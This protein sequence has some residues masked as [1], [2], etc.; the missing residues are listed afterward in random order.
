MFS[1]NQTSSLNT[2]LNANPIDMSV[3]TTTLIGPLVRN[4]S[5]S[6]LVNFPNNFDCWVMG[7]KATS[8]S[9]SS[10]GWLGLNQALTS[11]NFWLGGSGIR[12]APLLLNNSPSSN[13][14]AM[15]TSPSGKVH[16]KLVGAAP[17]RTLVVEYQNMTISSAVASSTTN[18]AT[19]Q[20]RVYEATGIIEFVYGNINVSGATAINGNIGFSNTLA[21]FQSI[22]PTNQTS[23]SLTNTNISLST[24]VFSPLIGGGTA[25]TCRAYVFTPSFVSPSA[26]S[27]AP[28]NS[29]SITLNWTNHAVTANPAINNEIYYSI[30]GNDWILAATLAPTISTYQL[31]GLLP[32]T[33]YLFKVIAIRESRS[34]ALAGNA[35]TLIAPL[36]KSTSS[37]G[38]W[39]NP[40]TWLGGV[41]PNV[42]DSV[43][44]ANGASVTIDTFAQ[45]YKLQVGEGVSGSLVYE[46]T[47][48]RLLSVTE[49]LMV[50]SGA[51]FTA[52]SGT[53]NFHMLNLGSAATAL[54][55]GNLINNGIF[56]M[57]TTA[58]VGVTFFGAQNASISGS[59]TVTDFS[60]V[61]LNK[62]NASANRPVLNIN[63]P[64]T[65]QGANTIG[66]IASH[67]AGTLKINGNFTQSNPIYTVNNY[68]IPLNA[69][70]V[71]NNPNFTITSTNGNPICNGLL[72]ITQGIFNVSQTAAQELGFGIGSLFIVEG[73][74]VNA[75]ARIRLDNSMTFN[76]SNGVINVAVVGNNQPSPSFGNISP[77]SLIN[78]S[79]GALNLV[80][81]SSVTSG[82]DYN[83]VFDPPRVVVTGGILNVGTSA[84]T[85]NFNFRISGLIPS[86]II[87]TNITKKTAT[88]SNTIGVARKLVVPQ[89][90][91]LILLANTL[92]FWGDSII[93]NGFIDGRHPNSRIVFTGSLIRQ[94]YAG[95]GIDSI[96]T[97]T[98][99]SVAGVLFNKPIITYGVVLSG[100]SQFMNSS[101][102]VLGNGLNQAVSVQFG[103]NG[104]N[105]LT[106][107][108]GFDVAPT[109]NMGAG[110][111]TL[112]YLREL[113]PRITGNEIPT[114]RTITNLNIQSFNNNVI[115]SGGN[116]YITGNL[117][118][119]AKI[120]SSDTAMLHLL[121]TQANAVGAGNGLSYIVGGLVRRLPA[122]LSGSS[123]YFFPLGSSRLCQAGLVNIKTNA[124]GT[125]DIKI[126]YVDSLPGGTPDGSTFNQFNPGYFSIEIVS[127]SANIDSTVITFSQPVL[128]RPA[129][130]LVYSNTLNGTYS[131]ISSNIIGPYTSNMRIG[132]SS[133][134]GFYSVG[135][136][137]IPISGNFLAGASKTAPHYT[138]ITQFINDIYQKELQ[139]NV[140]LLLDTDY[141]SSNETFPITLNRFYSNNPNWTITIKPNVGVNTVISGTSSSSIINILGAQKYIIDGSNNNST[142]RN[143]TV[144]NQS[145]ATNTAAIWISSYG[146]STG[147]SNNIIRNLKISCGADQTAST[148]NTFGVISCDYAAISI[149]SRGNKNDSNQIIN[150]EI[151]KVRYGIFSIGGIN[152]T[153]NYGN[154]IENNIIGPSSFGTNQ[155]GKAGIVLNA[156]QNTI[157]DNNEIRF[158]GG[159]F[160]QLAAGTDRVGISLASDAIWTPTSVLVKQARVTRN[161]IHD[162]VDEKIFSAIGIIVA[163]MD[164]TNNT[165]NVIANNDIYSISSNGTTANSR[166]TAGIAL[167]S[168]KQDSLLFNTVNLNGFINFSTISGSTSSFGLSIASSSVTNAI[169]R[170]NLVTMDV[171][172]NFVSRFNAAINIP[173][174]YVWGTGMCNNNLLFAPSNNPQ[175]R[176]GCVGGSNGTFYQTLSNWQTA[177][178]QDI[179]SIS[180]NPLL[181]SAFVS[182]P[183]LNS[184]AV[185]AGFAIAGHNIDLLDSARSNPPTI[186]AYE[187]SADRRPPSISFSNLTNDTS[188]TARNATS[189]AI[190][191]DS[192]GINNIPGLK[193]R[194][195][196]KKI[197]DANAFGAN[198]NSANGWKWVEA[199][200]STSPY[201]FNINY[202]LLFTTASLNDTIQYF[203]VAQ[204]NSP[205]ANISSFPAVGFQATSLSNIISAP[206]TLLTY[207]IVLPALAGNYFIGAGQPFL[208][209][210]SATLSAHESGV[211]A[212]VTFILTD[213]LY[214]TSTGE[215][216]PIEVRTI[217]GAS[218]INQVTLRPNNGIR[219]IIRDSINNPL[220]NLNGVNHF[221]I[222]G[223]Q[224]SSGLAK[225]LTVSNTHVGAN[226]GAVRFINDASNNKLESAIFLG[227]NAPTNGNA[228]VV[229][230][231]TG[232]VT[233]N[234]KNNVN[235]CE[236]GNASTTNRPST[237]IYSAGSTDLL[238]KFNDSNNVTNC[239]LYN[240]SN[241]T[242]EFNAFKIVNGNNT[243]TISENHVY[244]TTSIITS[245]L[246]FVFNLENGGN[247]NAL[248]NIR[249]VRN[250][251]GGSAPF[252]GGAPWTLSTSAGRLSSSFNLGNL[253]TSLFKR[254][255]ICNF[256]YNSTSSSTTSWQ[257]ANFIGG[258]LNI[259]SN[260]IGSTT[261]RDS[262]IISGGSNSRA[263]IISLNTEEPGEYSISG[264]DF[265]AIVVRSSSPGGASS[266]SLINTG[267][268]GSLSVKYNIGGNLF[269]NTLDS[270]ILNNTSGSF[271]YGI[272]CSTASVINIRNNI[273]RNFVYTNTIGTPFVAAITTSG[274][275]IDTI[276]DNHIFDMRSNVGN[277]IGIE[278]SKPS[279]AINNY[280]FRNR[281]F[282]LTSRTV[283]GILIT[284][285]SSSSLENNLIYGLA[286]TGSFGSLSGI[287]VNDWTGTGTRTRIIN[288]MIS[289]GHRTNGSNINSN[290]PIVGIGVFNGTVSAFNNSVYI[291]GHSVVPGFENTF[292]FSRN[293]SIGVDSILNNIFM[294]V[295]SNLTASG[296]KNYAL[297]MGSKYSLV[298][299]YNL[300][301]VD[302]SNFGNILARYEINTD[303]STLTSFKSAILTDHYSIS[304]NPN[305]IAPNASSTFSGLHIN[306]STPTP[307]ESAGTTVV[308]VITDFDNQN[309]AGLTPE[310]I[311]ADAGNFAVL[312]LSSPRISYNNFI[313][314]TVSNQ[315]I[316][317]GQVIVTDISGIHAGIFKPR[318]YY[319]KK[320]N[321]NIFSGN[322]SS[323]NGWKFVE[324]SNNTSPFNFIIDY[325]ILTGGG[326]VVGDTIQYFVIAQDSLGYLAAA[327]FAGLSA[328]SVI[329]IITAPTSPNF[330]AIIGSPLRGT[331]LVGPTQSAP[332]FTSLT[333]AV[334]E[335][336]LRGAGA[337]VIFELTSTLYTSP[338]E[339]FPIV[340]KEIP[341]SSALNS[342]TIKP[343]IGVNSHI[344]TSSSSPAIILD[345]ADYITIDGSNNG[346]TSRNLRF[347]TSSSV[348]PAMIWGR[349][350]SSN[351]PTTFNTIKNA[352]IIGTDAGIGIG[353]GSTHIGIPSFGIGN[354]NNTITN[355][356]LRNVS[357]G[358]YLSG[359]S[360]AVKD[361]NNIISFNILNNSFP[362]NVGQ[363]GI[364]TAFQNNLLVENN[365]I[366]N[367]NNDNSPIIGIAL[368]Y[369]MGGP[370][371]EVT[372]AIIRNNIIGPIANSTITGS[373]IAYGIL[374][375]TANSGI[376]S[377]HNNLISDNR[378]SFSL[379]NGLTGIY[380]GG[381]E[382]STT[383]VLHNT[384][385]LSGTLS[386]TTTNHYAVWIDTENPLV[387]MRNNIVTNTLITSGTGK[388]FAIGLASTT[389]SNMQADY[390]NYFV[391]GSLGKL[392]IS[393]GIGVGSTEYATLNAF[394]A[395]IGKD[396]NSVS[397]AVTFVSTTDAHLA[398]ASIGDTSL[399]CLLIPGITRDIDNELRNTTF[400][401]MGADEIVSNPLPVKLI[402]FNAQAIS[403]D[404]R[405]TWTTAAEVNNKGFELER[406]FD[407]KTFEFAQF[408]DG[409]G[410]SNKISSYQ[411][412]DAGI[413]TKTPVIYY[414]LKQ[415][416]FNSRFEYSKTVMVS[417]PKTSSNE[418]VVYPNPTSGIISL[419]INT[420]VEEH[421]EVT[422][423]DM[424]GK[425]VYNQQL[426]AQ[427]GNNQITLQK[428]EELISG[429]YFVRV[430]G[431]QQTQVIKLVKTN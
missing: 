305:F 406:S 361:Q 27:F 228:G 367:F 21:S 253:G 18:D 172:S 407:G 14:P 318:I 163:G 214:N 392:A 264:N 68:V 17:N 12:V 345:G 276:S 35:S 142:S 51:S 368:G 169:I 265:G 86:L 197:Q 326:V 366:G 398:G 53:N 132:A 357:T 24:G 282:G 203:V 217:P 431:Q 257:V 126:K 105:G 273:F 352:T 375:T 285:L 426:L 40:T 200:N 52:G 230:F 267:S 252:C 159:L 261:G 396:S 65:V 356:D 188:L 41:V 351:N 394:R 26:L 402:S 125:V 151:T 350:T 62:G 401:Y 205:W 380:L 19:F 224:T 66:L 339:S 219:A 146:G 216:F 271:L 242:N 374:L 293:V 412:I 90:T 195:Y 119:S 312:D 202:N 49:S 399:R 174:S 250:Y 211:V 183:Y 180:Q 344:R 154:R 369:N 137:I 244:Q 299:D 157:I 88:L 247:R 170:N 279:T 46:T 118:L 427:Q 290:I 74:V 333:Q 373:S 354:N 246:H 236:I 87:D 414:R 249:I 191:T 184:P 143:L 220:F 139:G 410:N 80:Q 121:N 245:A 347:S 91:S 129:N 71:L 322:T 29:T 317:N 255:K 96:S 160:S 379:T 320:T 178:G 122:S 38:S 306:P 311:G 292:A 111:Y 102:I 419:L 79:G 59:G 85:N 335:I 128:R 389:F 75:A 256:F 78:W 201:G 232:L 388:N 36:V 6:G 156:E 2:D 231:G 238:T 381:G 8:F 405:V 166:Q 243:W 386:N 124:G 258:K 61:T 117:N 226:A 204:D 1:T 269:G 123:T 376:N 309:R 186:G 72:Q 218:A 165:G 115:L 155:I 377:I 300:Y 63:I 198:N 325:T 32:A 97:I 281:I 237:L 391:S 98:N 263:N 235:N 428:S 408:I 208:T 328:T 385:T 101:N 42:G 364:V 212:P 411:Y 130:R 395:A 171:S 383:R 109:F 81:R 15:G 58:G 33:N 135:D 162:I 182:I 387:D 291:G 421:Y 89:G 275:G 54:S 136:L 418:V 286:V 319:K 240:Y 76:F 400:T 158:I 64:F 196:F 429:I 206:T 425:V 30:N 340:I 332:N 336:N 324:A 34:P 147:S 342:L 371:R 181:N 215:Q 397:K 199:N 39:K 25:T 303:Y 346:S 134:Q 302:T 222:D 390:N 116:L 360:V 348:L 140:T 274:T 260:S 327:P 48:A 84:T 420:D 112:T 359:S 294:N 56:D 93:N 272:Q 167:V 330:F 337:S 73:G 190:I 349:T 145:T 187:K 161:K 355:C 153:P 280:I 45:C 207:K 43:V 416:D 331:Y 310:D 296:G 233:G 173:T 341:Q 423:T 141:I 7:T 262:I 114:S 384:I 259:D 287:R 193:P 343:S 313:R 358:I 108:L 55:S 283:S 307:I 270:N 210:V 164:G 177:T 329:T 417:K 189:F 209:I 99:N 149:T 83:I 192:N 150:N 221:N 297:F 23:S 288:N 104:A 403:T 176:I 22:N 69:G 44:I 415:V 168:G 289:L 47:T 234:D 179:M 316:L 223:R 295:R 378:S 82:D 113:T 315:R 110:T 127:G 5:G 92:N 404:A 251:I 314:D 227:A 57:R 424:N 334:N 94:V 148:N 363:M 60:H 70:L 301:Y 106:T 277:I 120:I 268:T 409:A 308:G 37:G 422:I 133:I 338:S 278:I 16:Y 4:G 254:N 185:G 321:A 152:T 67:T 382:G 229:V 370:S 239:F 131:S 13:S 175:T 284:S 413:L 430:T 28:I 31:T 20:A 77:G 393:G 107:S 50:S 3:G 95:V 213:S 365:R 304:S 100:A 144:Q 323:N 298:S 362:N 266:L 372:N 194:I 10:H 241:P 9:V 103:S 138:T 353:F 248:N 11:V 225:Q